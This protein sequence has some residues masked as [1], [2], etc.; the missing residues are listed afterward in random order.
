MTVEVAEP[1]SDNYLYLLSTKRAPYH[2]CAN[3]PP[4]F[5]NIKVQYQQSQPLANEGERVKVRLTASC[6]AY[7]GVNE[8][9]TSF[10]AHN[11]VWL[12]DA[13]KIERLDNEP[14]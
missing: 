11:R 5:G 1:Q 13:T 7:Y 2:V 10:W 14:L 4:I 3:N 6:R 8:S 9:F 12:C